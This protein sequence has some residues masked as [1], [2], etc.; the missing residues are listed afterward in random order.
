MSEQPEQSDQQNQPEYIQIVNI[1][2]NE[3][4]NY[5][6]NI[7]DSY[8]NYL[9]NN[10]QEPVALVQNQYQH[11]QLFP[12][13]NMNIDMNVSGP[14]QAQ[15]PAPAP[16]VDMLV[17]GPEPAPAPL[18]PN[19][20][21]VDMHGLYAQFNAPNAPNMNMNVSGPGP[22]PAQLNAPNVDTH[23]IYAQLN[24]PNMN[25][26]MNMNMNISLQN[27][28]AEQIGDTIERAYIIMFEDIPVVYTELLESILLENMRYDDDD[29]N[30]TLTHTIRMFISRTTI[31]F[32]R[33]VAVIL[34]YASRESDGIYINNL[35][36]VNNY[37]M[38]YE[39]CIEEMRKTLTRSYRMIQ[40]ISLFV[41]TN[42]NQEMENVKLVMKKEDIISMFLEKDYN[43]YEQDI[44]TQNERCIFCQENFIDTDKCRKLNCDHVFH[45]SCID[46]WLENQNYKCPCCRT[47]AGPHHPK[48]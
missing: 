6:Y 14:A 36:F 45:T 34:N 2:G 19:A 25:M 31:S 47:E 3:G 44:K 4:N 20:Y 30:T 33:V 27:A 17:S 41:E 48:E 46:E 7:D 40:F 8:Y 24:A 37:D 43:T 9:Y 13:I 15:A 39:I 28:I 42:G 21:N 23:E 35:L 1:L 38:V 22:E 16:N 11:Q 32:D 10:A 18:P 29:V 5:I 12:N 26:N